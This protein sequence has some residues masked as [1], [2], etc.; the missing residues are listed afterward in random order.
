[1][2]IVIVDYELQ[3]DVVKAI[4]SCLVDVSVEESVS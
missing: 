4:K 2:A 1:M 3:R